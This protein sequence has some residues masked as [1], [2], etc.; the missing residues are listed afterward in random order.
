MVEQIRKYSLQFCQTHNDISFHSSL[1]FILFK[2]PQLSLNFPFCNFC[3]MVTF[4]LS[5][6]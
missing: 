5:V 4:M 6:S 1:D 2:Y 3:W